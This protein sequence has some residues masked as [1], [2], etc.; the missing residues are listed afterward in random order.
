MKIRAFLLSACLLTGMI[1]LDQSASASSLR[2]RTVP[3]DSKDQ[4]DKKKDDTKA[5]MPRQLSTSTAL[6]M[7]PKTT[8]TDFVAKNCCQSKNDPCDKLLAQGGVAK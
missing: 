6:L 8:S 7:S 4:K 5:S 1:A 3:K 2:V